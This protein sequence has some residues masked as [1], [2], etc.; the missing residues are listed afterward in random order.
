MI[1]Q[2]LQLTVRG[3]GENWTFL[4]MPPLKRSILLIRETASILNN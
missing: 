1:Y 2:T 3:L 4:T